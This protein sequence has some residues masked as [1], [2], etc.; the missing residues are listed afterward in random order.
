MIQPQRRLATWFVCPHS[1]PCALGSD[2]FCPQPR[3]E[4]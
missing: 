4:R 2:F 3:M 1:G